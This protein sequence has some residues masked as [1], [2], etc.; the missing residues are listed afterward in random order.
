MFGRQNP[1][2]RGGEDLPD[3]EQGE[4]DITPLTSTNSARC[5]V[6]SLR[7]KQA[8]EGG[9]GSLRM[10]DE[11]ESEITLPYQLADTPLTP[12]QVVCLFRDAR[13]SSTNFG[14]GIK[15]HSFVHPDLDEVAGRLGVK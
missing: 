5:E 10:V 14:C 12:E 9:K 8:K 1:R 4:V 13:P 15:L 7:A 11:Y 2:F 3:L 6:T